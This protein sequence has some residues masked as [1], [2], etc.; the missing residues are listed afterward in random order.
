MKFKDLLEK[1]IDGDRKKEWELMIDG[2]MP[3]TPSILKDFE[4]FI[5][6]AYH[7]TDFYEVKNIM[8]L[9]GKRKDIATFTKG[10]EGISN[11]AISDADVFFTLE[12]YSSFQA[13]QDFESVLDRNGHRWLNPL[14][15][16]DFIVNNK[17]S[18]PMKNAIIKE[19]NLEDRFDISSLVENMN[20]KEKAQFIKFYFEEAKKLTTKDLLK[21][22]KESITK[23]YSDKYTNDEVL[24]HNF[25]VKSIKLILDTDFE[26]DEY[27]EEAWNTFI[28]YADEDV[29]GYITRLEIE[30]I[31]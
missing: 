11:G 14:K 19:Y 18:V 15:D 1:Y 28:E 29:E 22:I 13:I 17:F 12:G 24:L 26:D 6:E 5:P 8:K 2:Y 9:Q 3:L 25:K 23:N 20:G 7:V 10:S 30:R 31:K 4:I 16:K 27:K 21:K